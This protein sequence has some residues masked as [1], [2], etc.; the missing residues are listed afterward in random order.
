MGNSLV[1][2]VSRLKERSRTGRGNPKRGLTR[3]KFKD[4][5]GDVEDG[6]KPLIIIVNK[7]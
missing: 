1:Q 7:V 5:I 3:L 4:D 6:Q 2:H